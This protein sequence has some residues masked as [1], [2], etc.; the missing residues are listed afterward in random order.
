[1]APSLISTHDIHCPYC[2]EMVDIQV[3]TSGGSA[4]FIEDCSVCC[5]PIEISLRVQA[6]GE[7]DLT[8]RR[9]DAV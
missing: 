3:D 1:M 8:A 5:R 6:N 2:G 9:D 7:I 4:E